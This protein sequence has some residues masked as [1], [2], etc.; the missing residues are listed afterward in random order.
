MGCELAH[1]DWVILGLVQQKY[2]RSTNYEQKYYGIW[3]EISLM[4]SLSET[5][6]IELGNGGKV[7]VGRGQ[8]CQGGVPKNTIV[9]L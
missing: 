4:N 5:E 6:E 7:T 1:E 8:I 9:K 2:S 3:C